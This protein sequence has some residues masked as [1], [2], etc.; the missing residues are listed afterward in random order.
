MTGRFRVALLVIAP[1]LGCDA[2]FGLDPPDRPGPPVDAIAGHD[3]DEDGVPDDDDVCPHLGDDQT[4]ADEDGVGDACDPE[5]AAPRQ[6]WTLFD[7]MTPDSPFSTDGFGTGVWTLGDDAWHYDGAYYGDIIHNRALDNVDVWFVIDILSVKEGDRQVSLSIERSAML[8]PYY[9][10]E[11]AERTEKL[12]G[13]IHF[14][15]DPDTYTPL[16]TVP[17]PG[18]I[19]PGRLTFHL[20]ARTAAAGAPPRFTLDVGWPGEP[21]ATAVDTV[22]YLG[23]NLFRL[24]FLHIEANVRSIAVITTMP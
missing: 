10:G 5:P 15:P 1:C 16:E 13:I 17:V 22:D 18:G 21:Y 4:D 19:R 7:R 3:E 6:R 20:G 8:V 9:L 2:I 24:T 11:I 14:M 23:A 12:A